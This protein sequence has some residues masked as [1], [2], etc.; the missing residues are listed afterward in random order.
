MEVGLMPYHFWIAL[1]IVIIV[2]VIADK[3]ADQLSDAL[4]PPLPPKIKT[5]MAEFFGGP[6]D[7]E[8]EEVPVL[9]DYYMTPYVSDDEEEREEIQGPVPGMKYFKP[10][11]AFYQHIMD[12]SYIYRRDVE[13]NEVQYVLKHGRLPDE[14]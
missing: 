12:G 13:D 5:H 1:A 4:K 2:Y 8:K 3:F 7:T 11:I 10:K 14:S 6:L 9:K